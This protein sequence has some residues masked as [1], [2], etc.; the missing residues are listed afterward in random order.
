VST[1]YELSPQAQK[2][3]EDILFDTADHRGR[4]KSLELEEQLYLSFEEIAR[5][6]NTAGHPRPDLSS[7]DVL[8]AF[9]DPY[10]V[11]YERHSLPVR[12]SAILHSARDTRD[13][14]AA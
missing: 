10:Y 8:F 4:T 14:C 12:I 9:T 1:L 11:I 3:L 6:P 7:K 13:C 5:S 2:Q